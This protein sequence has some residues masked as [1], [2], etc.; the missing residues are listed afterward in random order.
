MS[1]EFNE[2][3]QNPHANQP[4]IWVVGSREQVNHII[5]EFYVKRVITDCNQFSPMIPAPLA[6]GQYMTL[7]LR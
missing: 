1:T 6:P 7:L 2:L 3:L 5:N 4:Q